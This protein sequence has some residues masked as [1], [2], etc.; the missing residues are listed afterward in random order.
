MAPGHRS[1][2]GGLSVGIEPTI[3]AESKHTGAT[4][5]RI[6]Y[7]ARHT[8]IQEVQYLPTFVMPAS[9]YGPNAPPSLIVRFP[10]H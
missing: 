9:R 5:P 7:P 6:R 8:N 3:K 1:G 2:W 10:P 4:F